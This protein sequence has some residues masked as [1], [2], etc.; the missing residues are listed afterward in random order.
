MGVKYEKNI[1]FSF[2]ISFKNS[3]SAKLGPTIFCSIKPELIM[4]DIKIKLVSM[5]DEHTLILTHCGELMA[6]GKEKEK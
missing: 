2:F 1:E 4:N 6:C 3:T 5:G